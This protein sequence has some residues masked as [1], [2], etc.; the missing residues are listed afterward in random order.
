PRLGEELRG[1]RPHARRVEDKRQVARAV[2]AEREQDAVRPALHDP[3][4]AEEQTRPVRDVRDGGGC[5]RRDLVHGAAASSR[6]HDRAATPRA[7][8]RARLTGSS[9][10]GYPDP[11]RSPALDDVTAEL[12]GNALDATDP[13][14]AREV[15]LETLRRSWRAD[16]AV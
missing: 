14:H 3:E 10:L 15:L 6:A 4:A 12:V 13:A 7:P 16:R 1:E 5:T 11:M 2:I 9:A 8:P